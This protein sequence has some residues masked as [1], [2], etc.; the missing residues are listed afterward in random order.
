MAGDLYRICP[1]NDHSVDT[2]LWIG[3]KSGID[4]SH[5]VQ[6]DLWMRDRHLWRAAILW[7]SACG[8]FKSEI[9]W[10]NARTVLFGAHDQVYGLDILTGALKFNQKLDS[11]FGSFVIDEIHQS[12]FILTGAEIMCFDAS[13]FMLW[14]TSGLAVDG[15]VLRTLDDR[16][17]TV[18]ANM[19]P[20][21]GWQTV[22]IDRKTGKEE[23][24]Q[25][26]ANQ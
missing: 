26:A 22:F 5:R 1:A 14:S 7:E 13:L 17:I 18:D 20:P 2:L 19:D 12:V 21:G 10:T 15:V 25:P 23:S 11:Y 9:V 4:L 24:R 16:L 3:G 8:P 6:F